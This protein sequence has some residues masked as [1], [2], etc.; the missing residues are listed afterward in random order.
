MGLVTVTASKAAGRG[1]GRTVALPE[2][3]NIISASGCKVHAPAAGGMG[4]RGRTQRNGRHEAERGN[5]AVMA[6]T[7][8]EV[9]VGRWIWTSVP[10]SVQLRPQLVAQQAHDDAADDAH[11][12]G[13]RYGPAT[14][15]D[16]DSAAPEGPGEETDEQ[17]YLGEA[18]FVD[19]FPVFT[20]SY[21]ILF[22][23]RNRKRIFCIAGG[24]KGTS[25]KRREKGPEVSF[26][27]PLFIGS[28]RR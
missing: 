28:G 1:G 14:C 19:P 15:G 20:S 24:K 26:R 3:C 25:A 10:S 13:A 7:G 18:F 6:V 4:R 12:E 21:G 8:Q 2:K 23:L 22:P 16:T 5:M 9:T 11:G 17:A 27:P